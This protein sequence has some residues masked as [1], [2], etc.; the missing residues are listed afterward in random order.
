MLFRLHVCVKLLILQ[1]LSADC[2]AEIFKHVFLTFQR[3]DL[4]NNQTTKQSNN[5]IW[6]NRKQE[7]FCFYLPIGP[8]KIV[9]LFSCLIVFKIRFQYQRWQNLGGN[10][11]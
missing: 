10:P 1:P 2:L 6:T 5:I 7:K 11:K 8:N 4:K 9:Q 3:A